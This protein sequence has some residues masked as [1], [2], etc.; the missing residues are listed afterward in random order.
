MT[1][2]SFYFGC[3]V[4]D[5]NGEAGV[6]QGCVIDVNGFYPNGDQT[7]VATYGF[8]APNAEASPMQK[9]VLPIMFLGL[10]NITFGMLAIEVSK[11]LSEKY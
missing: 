10:K 9:A 4:F 8:N 3:T 2:L 11:G 5:A 6:A 1:F 7:G